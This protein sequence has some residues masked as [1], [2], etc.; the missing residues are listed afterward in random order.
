MSEIR[1]LVQD[2]RANAHRCP[3]D[4]APLVRQAAR[5]LDN[6]DQAIADDACGLADVL[7]CP[8]PPPE[9]DACP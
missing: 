2:L 4:V 6:L 8:V 3:E 9:A 1:E 5:I 7:P